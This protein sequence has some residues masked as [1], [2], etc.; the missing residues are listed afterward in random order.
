[1]SMDFGPA[2]ALLALGW[3]AAMCSPAL[4]AH[5]PGSAPN[6]ITNVIIIVQENRSFDSYFGTFPGANGIPPGACVPVSATD[7]TQGCV[8]PFHDVHDV[9]A[10]G[11][12]AATD[13][14][15]DADDGVTTQYM[16]GFVYRQT[17]GASV[18]CGADE[19]RP[20]GS[21]LPPYSCPGVAPGVSRHDVMGY[22]TAAEL[23]NYWA[24]AHGFVLQD[25]MFE[26][27]RGW[28]PGSHLDLTSEWSASC[29]NGVLSTCRTD[30]NPIPVKGTI[31]PWVNL[32]Q[33]LDQ[34]QVTWKYYLASGTEPDCDDDQ[35][36]CDP[37]VQNDGVLSLWNPAPGYA[38]VQAQG[39]AY[40]AAHNPDIDQFLV[41]VRAGT[42]PQ[43]SW[44]VPSQDF[45][46]HPVSGITAGQEYVTS[47][48]NA[49]MQSPY[50]ASTAIFVTWDDWGGFYDH[51]VPPIVDRNTTATPIQGFGFRVPGLLISPYAISGY[52]DHSVLSTDSYA[53]FIEQIF[54]GGVHL[55]PVAMGQPDARPDI[56]DELV[57]VTFPNG[58]TAPMG[59]LMNEFDFSQVPLAPMVLSTHIPTGISVACGG[60]VASPQICTG[61]AVLVK[62]HSVAGAEV[63]GP[64]TYQ[65][66]RDGAAMPKCVVKTNSCKDAAPSGVHFYTVA[67][68]STD[69]VMSPA[70][71]AT[72]ADAP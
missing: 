1:M 4:A 55:D 30:P 71:A 12:H 9:N 36:T 43:V 34:H 21:P 44:V 10:G 26:G 50:W 47:M 58:T 67:S 22:H 35:M 32:F 56:R 66:F 64:F 23:P 42:L 52:V 38:Y 53:T 2:K 31:Y 29:K 19:V 24:Y 70:S 16:D 13:A 65:V 72:E 61:A 11:P 57:T 15:A 49:V 39:A 7:A 46:E 59:S 14:Q 40:L 45:S 51:V 27:V 8:A 3:A 60:A 62:W 68:V 25:A 17:Y 63:P 37:Q 69:G 48:V 41:D 28:S 54:M 6:P 33:L 18:R 5:K 20:R